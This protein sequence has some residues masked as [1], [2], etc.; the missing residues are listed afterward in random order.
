MFDPLTL[1]DRI[2]TWFTEKLPRKARILIS[3]FVLLIVVGTGYT[4]F[5]INEY[6]EHDPDACRMCHVHDAAHAAWQKSEHNQVTCHDCHHATRQ[7]Q[8]MQIVKFVFL[9]HKTVS[10]RHGEIIV[11]KKFCM[12]C[13]WQRNKKYPDAPNVSNSQYHIRHATTASL[14]CTQCHGYIIHKFPTDERFCVKCHIGKEVHGTGMERLACL[15][16]HTDRTKNLRPERK[17]CLFCHGNEQVREELIRGGT[18]DVKHFLPSAETVNRAIKIIVPDDAPM[19]FYCYECHKPHDAQKVRP[20][21]NDCLKCHSDIPSAGKHE[22]HIKT[23][24]L[25]CQDCHK[26][27]S[28]RVTEAQAK[29]ECIVCHEYR[30]PRRFLTL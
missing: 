26:P 21:W 14:E 22:L 16:C 7:D 13:H 4:G 3:V 10:P 9:G 30:D 6:F 24:G 20:D 18:I 19:Q 2:I 8:V 29:K 27:H 25:R 15:N 23:V 5:R 28:W 1:I 11:P 17:K 12:N